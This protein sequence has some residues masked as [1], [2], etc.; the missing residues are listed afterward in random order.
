[1]VMVFLVDVYT[2]YCRYNYRTDFDKSLL[3]SPVLYFY[4]LLRSPRKFCQPG[5]AFAEW[6]WVEA[7]RE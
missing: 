4:A 3:L 2:K 6:L 5:Q 7:L 1:M